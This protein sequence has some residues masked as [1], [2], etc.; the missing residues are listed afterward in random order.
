VYH[1]AQDRFDI[2]PSAGDPG[3][4]PSVNDGRVMVTAGTISL[5]VG[6]RILVAETNVR[7]SIQPASRDARGKAAAGSGKV[8]SMLKPDEIVNVRANRLEYDGANA[9]GVYTGDAR[10]WQDRTTIKGDTITVDDKH[11]NLTSAGHVVS[12][13]FFEET[14]QATKTKKLVQ[15]DATGDRMVYEDARRVATYTTGPTGIAHIVGSQGDVVADRIQLFLKPGANE[16]ERAEGDGNVTVKEGGRTA[17]GNHLTYTAA[18]D[19]YVMTGNPLELEERTPTDCRVT[20]GSTLSFKR[21]AV[22]TLIQNN[23]LT[24]N[25]FKPC[26]SK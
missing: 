26:A 12:V 13:M 22:S 3:P 16:L 8:P 21:A 25:E 18:D 15:M 2:A 9:S 20:V 19:T 17:T 23:G 6:T 7:S 11:G 1:I 5:T 4:P 14:D 24:P 10:L